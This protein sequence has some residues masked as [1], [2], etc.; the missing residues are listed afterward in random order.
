MGR[1]LRVGV[2]GGGI[3]GVALAGAL[4]QRGIEVKVFERAQ[5]FGDFVNPGI[6]HPADLGPQAVLDVSVEPDEVAGAG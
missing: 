1:Q 4:A 6:D 5:A 3:G 2:I